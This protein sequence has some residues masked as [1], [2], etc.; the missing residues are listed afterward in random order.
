MPSTACSIA[1]IR[2]D[3]FLKRTMHECLT[4][5]RTTVCFKPAQVGRQVDISNS[6]EI[7]YVVVD[8]KVVVEETFL[9]KRL[10]QCALLFST[11]FVILG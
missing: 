4:L 5:S 8:G 6:F 9:A 3:V 11:D 10:D 1:S 7:Q 2:S